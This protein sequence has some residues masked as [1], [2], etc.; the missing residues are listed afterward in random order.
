MMLRRVEAIYRRF[1]SPET[2]AR[3]DR[4]NNN[5]TQKLIGGLLFFLK[6]IGNILIIIKI[7]LVGYILLLEETEYL[8][9]TLFAERQQTHSANGNVSLLHANPRQAPE[10]AR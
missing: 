8:H 7:Y 9:C 2:T 6:Y 1:R 5:G 3:Y 10:A 4:N